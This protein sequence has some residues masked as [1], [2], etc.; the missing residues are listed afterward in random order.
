MADT[1]GEGRDAGGVRS[2]QW[3]AQRAQ[4]AWD[5]EHRQPLGVRGQSS[6][7]HLDR[8]RPAS[9]PVDPVQALRVD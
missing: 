2:E 5:G 7:Q 4:E 3:A 6:G 1:D 9:H 8:H